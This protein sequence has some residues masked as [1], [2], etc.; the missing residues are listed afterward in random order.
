VATSPEAV[1]WL[2]RAYADHSPNMVSLETY[3]WFTGSRSDP[4]VRALIREVKF[5]I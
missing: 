2:E 5:P 1:A 4:R 3:E